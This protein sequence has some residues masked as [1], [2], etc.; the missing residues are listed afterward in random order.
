MLELI[1]ILEISRNSA[2]ERGCENSTITFQPILNLYLNFE[3]MNFIIQCVTIS[4]KKK[5]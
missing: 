3:G 4:T 5:D 2:P 1:Q